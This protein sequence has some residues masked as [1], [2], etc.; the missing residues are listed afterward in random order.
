MWFVGIEQLEEFRI[1]TRSHI[2]A[3]R[4]RLEARELAGATIRR[5]LAALSSLFEQR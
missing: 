3:W 2:I 5:K 4:K 1:V